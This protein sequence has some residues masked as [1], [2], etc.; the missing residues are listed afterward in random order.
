MVRENTYRKL[1][2]RYLCRKPI[3]IEQCDE[4]EFW[5]FKNTVVTA[6]TTTTTTFVYLL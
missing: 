3:T 6:T 2:N 1:I 5:C 4:M